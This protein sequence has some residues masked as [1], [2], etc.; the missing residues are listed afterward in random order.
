MIKG[1]PECLVIG[2]DGFIGRH[3]VKDLVS[4]GYAVRAFD[5]YK[6]Y[7]A[8]ATHDQG[9]PEMVELF[10]GDFLNR[11]D[12]TD[13][14]DGVKYVFHLVS[15][16]NPSVSANDPFID[17]DTNVRGSIEL[18]ELCSNS[19]SVKKV[20]FFSSGGTVYGEQATPLLH[21]ELPLRPQS[22]YAIG[23]AAIEYYLRYFKKVNNLDYIVYRIANPYGPGQNILAKQGVI[24][25]FLHHLIKNEP[26]TVLGDGSMIRD[27]L[28]IS[29]VTRMIAETFSKNNEF[30]VYNIGSGG[31]KS[32]NDLIRSIESVTGKTFKV[33]HLEQPPTFVHRS[34]LDTSRI[35]KEF[36]VKPEVSLDEGMQR[37]WDY[38]KGIEL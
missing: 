28:Y 17:I 7:A 6:D 22:P 32:V 9:S 4:R 18:F 24:P 10:P 1:S 35:E 20:I 29:D 30:D 2:A 12:L 26:V 3:L 37:T 31:G 15:M 23:K 27:Y 11:N 14:L 16:T 21:E 5:R 38:V 8:G 19:D 25:I 36:G 34:V 33:N 13:A